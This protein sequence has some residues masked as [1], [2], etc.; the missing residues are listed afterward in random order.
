MLSSK[1]ENR[2]VETKFIRAL[3]ERF[4]FSSPV[5]RLGL[6][7]PSIFTG[8]SAILQPLSGQLDEKQIVRVLDSFPKNSDHEKYLKHALENTVQQL[9]SKSDNTERGMTVKVVFIFVDGEL[10]SPRSDE[11]YAN[12]LKALHFLGITPILLTVNGATF[13]SVQPLAV[14]TQ[15]RVVLLNS[16]NELKDI[17]GMLNNIKQGINLV[18]FPI[19]CLFICFKNWK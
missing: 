2:G 3:F 9:F 6:I 11:V 10:S 14:S 16:Q 17:V 15:T 5:T 19:F 18:L 13:K 1:N 12:G 4:H 8:Q 7:S